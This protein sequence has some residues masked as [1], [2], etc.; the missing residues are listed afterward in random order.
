MAKLAKL[1]KDTL[2]FRLF[3]GNDK[4]VMSS[5]DDINRRLAGTGVSLQYRKRYNDKYLIVNIDDMQV[6]RVKRL[7]DINNRQRAAGKT[8]RPRKDFSV[9]QVLQWQAEGLSNAEIIR[10]LGI[11]KAGFYAK[12]K[13]YKESQSN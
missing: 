8:G 2:H 3:N 7:V 5:I 6:A 4:E 12:M 1:G 10:R 9:E 11:S 13:E